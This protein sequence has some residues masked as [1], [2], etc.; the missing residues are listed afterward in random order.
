MAWEIVKA[1]FIIIGIFMA[2]G[3]VYIIIS[4]LLTGTK[5]VIKAI[6]EMPRFL[7]FE[8]PSLIKKI[9]SKL[10]ETSIKGILKYMFENPWSFFVAY[11]VIGITWG[12][13]YG[14]FF[15]WWW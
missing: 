6:I 5:D 1:F 15:S 11:V 13:I 14:V 7:V 9:P 10:K 8:L 3:L 12:I 2:I 4:G